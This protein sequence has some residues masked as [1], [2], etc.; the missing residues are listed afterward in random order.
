MVCCARLQKLAAPKVNGC[1]AQL[2]SADA[3]QYGFF[4]DALCCASVK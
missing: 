3:Y 1:A 4:K 2:C